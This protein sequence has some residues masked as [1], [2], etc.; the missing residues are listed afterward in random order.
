MEE[1]F[2]QGALDIGKGIG[3]KGF[4]ILDWISIKVSTFIGVAPENV[5]LLIL[6]GISM[7][8]ANII[9]GREGLGIKF[10]A[11]TIGLFMGARYL[12]F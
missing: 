4:P 1:G 10:W 8:V 5:H 2:L 12:G 7:Y 11:I 3:E 9:A 6:G